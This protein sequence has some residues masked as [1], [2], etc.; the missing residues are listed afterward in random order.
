MVCCCTAFQNSP[1]QKHERKWASISQEH[2]QCPARCGSPHAMFLLPCLSINAEPLLSLKG[3]CDSQSQRRLSQHTQPTHTS[4]LVAAR[5][6]LH[7][8]SPSPRH[9]SSCDDAAAASFA[10]LASFSATNFAS[11]L[12]GL[13]TQDQITTASQKT[14]KANTNSMTPIVPI[15]DTYCC[16]CFDS[17]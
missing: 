8:H 14:T 6:H 9:H 4:V 16:R 3:R 2:C 17:Q 1:Y 5:L 10:S 12:L 13:M 15:D 11:S 7:R